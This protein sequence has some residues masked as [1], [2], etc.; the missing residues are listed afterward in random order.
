M[1]TMQIVWTLLMT[2]EAILMA[3]FFARG[4]VDGGR[5][6]ALMFMLCSLE[7]KLEDRL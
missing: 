2:L 7:R 1:K 4:D 3:V 5:F 6:C